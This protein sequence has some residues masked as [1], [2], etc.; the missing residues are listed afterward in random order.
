MA[1][2]SETTELKGKLE[3]VQA[4]VGKH[5]LY[6]GVAIAVGAIFGVSGAFGARW[7]DQVSGKV[8]NAEQRITALD[9]NIDARYAEAE[10]KAEANID[11]WIRTRQN[12]LEI[13]FRNSRPRIEELKSR[14]DTISSTLTEMGK[15]VQIVDGAASKKF[16]GMNAELYS[17]SCPANQVVVG[18][19]IWLGGTCH[20]QCNADGRPVHFFRV[21]CGRR[22]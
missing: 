22:L 17:S 10:R 20:E 15:P 9:Q 12:Q 11:G 18:L 13:V 1:T 4:K 3:A 16:G 2:E 8:T 7:I 14:V 19:D 21:K 6:F 5:D